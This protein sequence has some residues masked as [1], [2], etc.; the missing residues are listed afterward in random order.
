MDVFKSTLEARNY[1]KR[2]IV[3]SDQGGVYTSYAYQNFLG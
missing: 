3:H 2:M 1:P